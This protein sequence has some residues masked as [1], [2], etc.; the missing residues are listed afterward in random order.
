MY[1][2]DHR[3]VCIGRRGLCAAGY[4]LSGGQQYAAADPTRKG[5]C[6]HC[7]FAAPFAGRGCG[8]AYD[9]CGPI[10][11]APCLE[12]KRSSDPHARR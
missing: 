3:M 6:Y 2:R 8:I 5:S 1:H 4:D 9:R 11:C 10:C 7:S 12:N